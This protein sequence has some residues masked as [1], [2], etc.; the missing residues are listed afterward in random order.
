MPIYEVTADKLRKIEAT[1]FS[2][3]GLRE[4]ADL[5]RLLRSQIDIIAP[6]VLIIAEEFG[7]WEDSRRRIDLL[8][9]D[10]E[11]NLVIVE[12]K[13]TEDG[14]HMEL[15]ALRY[16][17]MISN[18]TF[19]KAVEVYEEY[20]QSIN[21][22]SDASQTLLEFLNWTEPNEE[23]F[24]Q[25][26][27]I[28]LASAEFSKE[29]TSSVLWLN[30]YGLD[31]RC[32]RFKP[33]QDNGRILINVEQIIPLPEANEYQIQVSTKAQQ[34]RSAR[35]TLR[36]TNVYDVSVYGNSKTQQA[37]R[38]AIFHIVKGLCNKGVEP[39]RI[40]ALVNWKTN[41][42]FF[43]LDGKLNSTEFIGTVTNAE[44][45]KL[46]PNRYYCN[47]EE[48]F[49]SNGKTFAF[50]KMWGNRTAE[51]IRILAKEFPDAKI[52]FKVSQD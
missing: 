11:A 7:E 31:I 20:L 22:D 33:Y 17:A 14:G 45:R 38:N 28:V 12:L 25:D 18:M 49:Y 23:L 46:D 52:E 4:R 41:T 19:E 39:E 27:R 32:V 5:Q 1:T 40:A 34:K 8:G 51:A 10:K 21:S 42:I 29:I 35:T 15:Q 50:T 3:A 6:D 30:D 37:K 44:G 36:D 43:T 2:A 24:A 9:I 26:V 48:L 16:A 13:R 47:D